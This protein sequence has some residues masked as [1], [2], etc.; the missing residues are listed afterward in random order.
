MRR[1][2]LTRQSE[3]KR[4]TALSSSH[5]ATE[6]RRRLSLGLNSTPTTYVDSPDLDDEGVRNLTADEM[7][8]ERKEVKESMWKAFRRVLVEVLG[9]GPDEM[10]AMRR[11]EKRERIE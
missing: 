3:L 9:K 8:G 4:T 7:G 6:L 10:P 5:I 11:V 1:P 2:L